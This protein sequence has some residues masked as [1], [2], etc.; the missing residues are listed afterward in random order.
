MK[1]LFRLI[2]AYAARASLFIA[3][4]LLA[5]AP[6][7]ADNII[8]RWTGEKL[9]GQGSAAV[10]QASTAEANWIVESVDGGFVLLKD[11][12]SGLYLNVETGALTLSAIQPGWWS[13]QWTL[14]DAGEGYVRIKNRWKGTYLHNETKSLAAGAI[15]PGWWSAQWKRERYFPETYRAPTAG[16]TTKERRFDQY[17]WLT[18]HNAFINYS[19]A[20]WTFPNQSRGIIGQLTSNGVRGLQLD[21]YDFTGTSDTRG[22]VACGVTFS[23]DCYPAGVYMCHADCVSIAGANY[24][25]PR[26]SLKDTM[27]AIGDWLAANTGEQDVIT[28]FFEDYTANGTLA[29]VIQSSRAAPYIFNPN[30]SQWS[31]KSRGWPTLRAMKAAD[32]RLVLFTSK[33]ANADT[34]LGLSHDQSFNVE[35][36]WSLGD[37]GTNTECKTRWDNV[38]LNA[39]G[40]GF[41]RLFL[42]NHYRNVPT[43]GLSAKDNTLT[44]LQSR[45]IECQKVAERLPN[46][47]ALDFVE[48]GG[49]GDFI[50]DLNGQWVAAANE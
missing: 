7:W 25:F 44:N 18:S 37:M 35:N 42:M 27:D 36:Y 6:A 16:R 24:A 14:E 41:K 17:A 43:T 29:A 20:R 12:K 31:V 1:T 49:A 19:D 13:A 46:Y 28:I 10:M 8:N 26:Q 40:S 32:K 3:A 47:V 9:A 11:G 50:V 38:P 23:G 2:A 33:S 15:Q 48:L 34:N 39:N 30:D 22:I 45:L 4:S 21:V 5:A